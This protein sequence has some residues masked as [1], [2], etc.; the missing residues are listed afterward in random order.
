MDVWRLDVEPTLEIVPDALTLD[1][2]LVFPKSKDR[3]VLL[4]ALAV[5]AE[6]LLTL[7]RE[8]FQNSIGRTIYGM[9]IRTPGEFLM[10]ER[11]VGRI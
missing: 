11:R 10:D 2:L 6:V 7:D 4:A 8:D 5:E 3:P 9:A 1:K